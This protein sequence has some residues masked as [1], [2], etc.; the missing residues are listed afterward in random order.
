MA[1]EDI[2]R[3]TFDTRKQYA[4]VRMQQGRVLLDQD[5]N[6]GAQIASEELRRTRLD[7]VG[8]AASPDEGFRV[9]NP[10]VVDGQVDFDIVAGA[11]YLGGLRLELQQDQSYRQQLDNLQAPP[12]GTSPSGTPPAGNRVDLAVLVAYEQPV[13]AVE[14]SELF[15]VA[16]GGPD[17]TTRIRTMQRVLLWEDLP[18][19][20][21]EVAWQAALDLLQ[22]KGTGVLNAEHELVTDATLTVTFQEFGTPEDLC[23]PDVVGGYLGAE[24]QAIRVQLVD[25]AHLTWGFNNAAPLYRVQVAADRKTVTLL[26]EPK[27]QA[28]WPLAGQVVELLPW[29]AVLPNNEK[30]AE[31]SGHLTRVTASYNPDTGLIIVAEAV[32]TAGFDDWKS[33]DDAAQLAAA[34]EYYFLRVWDRGSDQ[35]SAPGIAFTPGTPVTL[36]NTGLRITLNGA[37]FRARDYWVVAARPDTP[38]RVVPWELESGR[39]PHGPHVYIAPLALIRWPSDP[40]EAV[41]VDDC[42][43]RFRPLVD[44]EICCSYT[45]GDG[46]HS[47]GD[48]DSIEEALDRL[49]AAGGRLCLL[50]GTHEANVTIRK[51]SNIT[52]S[53][54]GSNTRVTPRPGQRQAPIFH[55][56][57]AQEVTLEHLDMVTLEGA[58]VVASGAKQG[59][60]RGLVVQHNRMLAYRNAV[61]VLRGEGVTIA[62]N[63]LRM[64]D[65]EGGDVAIYLLAEH[66]R[67]E[68]NDIGVAPPE[69]T[70]PA[71]E[72]DDDDQPEAPNPTDP[73]ADPEKFY[74]NNPYFIAYVTYVW[75][76]ALFSFIPTR[77]FKTLGGIQVGSGSQQVRIVENHIAGGAGNGVTLGSDLDLADLTAVDEEPD[78]DELEI[79]VKPAQNL[80]WGRVMDGLEPVA[81]VSLSFKGTTETVTTVTDGEGQFIEQAQDE[82]YTVALADT[83]NALTG[84]S[85][86]D[87]DEFGRFHELRVARQVAKDDLLHVLDTSADITITDNDIANMGLSGIGIPVVDLDQV[88]KLLRKSETRRWNSPLVRSL[89]IPLTL[90]DALVGFVNNLRVERNHISRCLRNPLETGSAAKR[91]RAA[92]LRGVG[93]ISLGLCADLAIHAN[94]IEDNGAEYLGPAHG[95]FVI[96][97]SRADIGHNVIVRNG[98]DGPDE[99]VQGQPGGVTL[100]IATVSSAPSTLD[101]EAALARADR[102]ALRFHDNIVH[103]PLGR[104]LTVML[105]L[106]PIS[107]A[108][109]QLST[110]FS[111]AAASRSAL[112]GGESKR[113]FAAAGLTNRGLAGAGLLLALAQNAATVL[114]T[115]L[116]ASLALTERGKGRQAKAAAAAKSVAARLPTGGTLFNDNQ[117][118]LGSALQSL[119]SQAIFVL[120]DI[121]YADNQA[122]VGT[123]DL[124][125]A[126]AVLFAFTSL[127]ASGNRL[128]EP[129]AADQ[130]RYSMMTVAKGMNSTSLNQGDHCIVA[131]GGRLLNAGNLVLFGAEDECDRLTEQL[132]LGVQQLAQ[133]SYVA[134]QKSSRM[135]AAGDTKPLKATADPVQDLVVPVRCA[136]GRCVRQSARNAVGR[137]CTAAA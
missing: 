68:R 120:D 6:D 19:A 114:I 33:R 56:V 85:S 119:V 22:A 73:C 27:D 99:Q 53:G 26:T 80:L 101:D 12:S 91:S 132:G 123:G 124:L 39:P 7:V 67:I 110:D 131:Q 61:H 89:A 23:T 84:V 135:M 9:A 18:G 32:P 97:A 136:S 52:I 21:C 50:P 112:R 109:N 60:L 44:Q 103:Q 47:H 137:A 92:L 11:F 87:Q 35:A 3:S 102:Q 14:D 95:I 5:W 127:R 115:N 118:R 77:P 126:N 81:G 86:T 29:A 4:G 62:H 59:Q 10:R 75:S 107:V 1:T 104:A 51:R 108:D 34:G 70:P 121:S 28:H 24:N 94:R 116:G 63:V 30:I 78:N 117:V 36:G 100:F 96:Y 72:G 69:V 64:L 25:E 13:S 76:A 65:K 46:K 54:C 40:E 58:A 17:T 20:S 93:G 90:F 129:R 134:Y 16:L 71:P 66:A 128:Q 38:H 82:A 105:G 79:V 15:E 83:S 113:S 42:R 88:V 45:V 111:A 49:P 48:F 130:T 98:L 55:V 2:S 37:Q 106:G 57:D 8:A 43:P 125:G 133:S 31:A 41:R 122:Y 74:A